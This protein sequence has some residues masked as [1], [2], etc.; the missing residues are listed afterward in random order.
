MQK[1]TKNKETE[2]ESLTFSYIFCQK[3]YYS[4]EGPKKINKKNK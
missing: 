2:E 1:A 3:G 4:F